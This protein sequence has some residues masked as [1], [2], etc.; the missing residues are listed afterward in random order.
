MKFF[1]EY[2]F[3][4]KGERKGTC[5]DLCSKKFMVAEYFRGQVGKCG[6][7]TNRIVQDSEMLEGTF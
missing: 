2:F 4:R 6:N 5:C 3:V 1:C 7:S